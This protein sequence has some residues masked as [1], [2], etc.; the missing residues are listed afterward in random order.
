MSLPTTANTASAHAPYRRA[1][2]G[3]PPELPAERAPLGTT[4][5]SRPP[6]VTGSFQSLVWKCQRAMWH[7][8]ADKTLAGCHR[9]RAPGVTE[10]D[11]QRTGAGGAGKLGGLQNSHSVWGSPVAATGIARGRQAEVE[12]ATRN[13][14]AGAGRSVGM[15]TLTVRH[16]R[17]ESLAEL[18]AGLSTAWTKLVSSRAF[19]GP[20]GIRER[21]GIAHNNWFLEIT[22]GD[23]GWHPHRHMVAFFERELSA[24]ELAALRAE[25]SVKW[26]ESVTKVGLLTPSA[27]RGVD[28]AQV[29]G[30]ESAGKVGVYAAKGQFAGLAA[31]VTGGAV[32]Q[33]R[34]GNRTPFEIL[35]DVAEAL[36]AGRK[37]SARDVALWREYE[38]ATKGKQQRRWSVGA[39]DALGVNIVGEAELAEMETTEEEQA[40]TP[41]QPTSLVAIE[42]SGWRML[43]SNVALR[44][45]LCEAANTGMNAWAGERAVRALLDRHG[46]PYRRVMVAH[47][48]QVPVVRSARWSGTARREARAVLESRPVQGVLL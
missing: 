42:P 8:T 46:V 11:V 30:D 37:P 25:L 20:G 39:V 9:W 17:H 2:V 16:R 14:L 26:A 36:D 5:S 22:H 35:L 41:E 19:K 4:E 45:E 40:T 18:L 31:E 29:T 43:A 27:E 48:E 28:V 23:N 32:K 33:A 34:G 10:V 44:R 6:Q 24:D 15:I 21:Y 47:A 12:T 38:Q 13:W 1:V 7:I 3:N